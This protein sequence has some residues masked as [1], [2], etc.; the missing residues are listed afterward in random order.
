MEKANKAKVPRDCLQQWPGI[1]IF[2]ALYAVV[3]LVRDRLGPKDWT[4]QH[5]LTQFAIQT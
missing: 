1:N 3:P 5:V 4:K 2:I